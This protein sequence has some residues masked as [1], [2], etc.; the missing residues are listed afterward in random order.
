MNNIYERIEEDCHTDFMACSQ[1]INWK[2]N[3]IA[4]KEHATGFIVQEL[5]WTSVIDNCI[6]CFYYYEAWKVYNGK[7]GE[8]KDKDDC[9]DVFC[10]G[11]RYGKGIYDWD[12]ARIDSIGHCGKEEWR[13]LIYWVDLDENPDLY[14]QIDN[15]PTDEVGRAN[16]LNAIWVTSFNKNMFSGLKQI[17]RKPFIHNWD[18][19]SEEAIWQVAEK[20]LFTQ[21]KKYDNEVD[22]RNFELNIN[23]LF[24]DENY[25]HI[26]EQLI[27]KW[28]TEY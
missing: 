3:N 16:G 9:D 20:F 24:P 23:D 14:K 28:E 22:R 2:V 4:G 1:C 15:W 25:R 21:C 27:R 7:C 18:V 10:I 26:K 13:G 5:T 11:A 8:N 17:I 19:R 6:N 12:Q